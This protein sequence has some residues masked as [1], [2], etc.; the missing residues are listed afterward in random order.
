MWPAQHSADLHRVQVYH[1]RGLRFRIGRAGIR[2]CEDTPRVA[3]SHQVDAAWFADPEPR[4]AA[5]GLEQ[6]PWGSDTMVMNRSARPVPLIAHV[7][8]RLDYG[9]LENGLVNLINGMPP[10]RYR[11]CV[12]ALTEASDF[13]TRITRAGV[14]V[15]CIGKRPGKDPGAYIRLYRLLRKLKPTIVHTRNLGTLECL[16]VAWL[17]RAPVRIHGEH[18]WDIYDPDGT[19]RKYRILRRFLCRFIDRFVTVSGELAEWL[20]LTVG[21]PESKVTRICNGVDTEKFYPRGNPD[22]D[23]LPSDIFPEDCVIVGS[24]TRFSAIKDPLN[25][26]NA[27]IKIKNREGQVGSNSRLLMI[28]GG[29]MHDKAQ[30]C[31][32]DANLQNVAWL[33]GSRD[34]IPK[35]LRKMDIFVLSSLREGISNT[36]LEAM[37]SGLPVIATATGGNCELVV[38]GVTGR[39]VPSADSEALADAINVYL[40]DATIRE[41]HGRN[42]RERACR[43]F[44]ITAM[45]DAYLRLY[46]D[47]LKEAEI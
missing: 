8:F 40:S 31:V 47:V 38:D 24:V 25:L 26:L 29:E 45:V 1:R 39:L 41:R 35:M 33:C 5:Y 19:R 34:D 23:T 42:A 27:F 6:I 4:T 18:G 17:A 44:S 43:L 20:A 2:L 37:A 30:K 32:R 9:G 12:I 15:H 36:V 16:F 7:V 11:H 28:G 3:D 10:D 13:R 46:R 22:R 21:I 14:I